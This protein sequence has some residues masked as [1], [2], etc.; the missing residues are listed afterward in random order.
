[1]FTDEAGRC[2]V[3]VRDKVV[4]ITTPHPAR[5]KGLRWR[6]GVLPLSFEQAL[7]RGRDEVVTLRYCAEG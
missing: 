3:L 2:E 7:R 4:V 5:R 6:A 1:V